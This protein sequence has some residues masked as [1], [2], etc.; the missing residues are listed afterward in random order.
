M[1]LFIS[2]IIIEKLGPLL[3]A[4]NHFTFSDAEVSRSKISFKILTIRIN[5]GIIY[6]LYPR[7]V[8]YGRTAVNINYEIIC[9]S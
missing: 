2:K 6:R 7:V 3:G 1:R 8:I 5:F 4:I 9:I